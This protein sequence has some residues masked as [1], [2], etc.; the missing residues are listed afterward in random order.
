[1]G[2][3]LIPI[4]VQSVYLKNYVIS[5]ALP[6]SLSLTEYPIEGC[7]FALI[8]KLSSIHNPKQISIITSSIYAYSELLLN[9]SAYSYL[10]HYDINITAVL[11]K[12]TGNLDEILEIIADNNQLNQFALRSL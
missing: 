2:P 12:V 4:S 5:Q 10:S 3:Y 9:T 11:E 1:M 6:F 7:Y 8:Q